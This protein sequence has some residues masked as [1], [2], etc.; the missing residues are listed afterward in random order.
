MLVVRQQVVYAY[1]R[2][3]DMGRAPGWVAVGGRLL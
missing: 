3:S 2:V 1:R